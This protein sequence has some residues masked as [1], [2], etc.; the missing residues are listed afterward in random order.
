MEGDIALVLERDLTHAKHGFVDILRASADALA[1]IEVWIAASR[2]GPSASSTRSPTT[3][4]AR[5]S[6]Q[7]LKAAIIGS[8]NI[9]THMKHA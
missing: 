6:S 4:P 3:R 1:A 7:S 8:G 2:T 5:A 9:G